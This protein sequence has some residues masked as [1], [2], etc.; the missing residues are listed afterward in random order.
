MN[1]HK[2]RFIAGLLTVAF[3]FSFGFSTIVYGDQLLEHVTVEKT[4]GDRF[5]VLD[6]NDIWEFIKRIF[7][8]NN[9]RVGISAEPREIIDGMNV[10]FDIGNQVGID[11]VLAA[12]AICSDDQCSSTNEILNVVATSDGVGQFV[13]VTDSTTY[14]N[15][16]VVNIGDSSLDSDGKTTGN[17]MYDADGIG[18]DDPLYGYAAANAICARAFGS[19]SHVCTED[20]IVLTI[21][22]N[23]SAF[24]AF[25]TETFGWVSGGGSKYTSG[26]PVDDCNGFTYD[27]GSEHVGNIWKLNTTGGAGSAQPCITSTRIACCL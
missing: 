3:V 1:N 16:E 11:G 22:S 9:D 18:G 2:K 13:G 8:G 14:N 6:F 27:A 19:T 23:V 17:I 5:S 26:L 25:T 21:N 15:I 4:E 10:T 20:E 12:D 24:S 7:I